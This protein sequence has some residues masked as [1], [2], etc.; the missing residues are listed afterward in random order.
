[1]RDAQRDKFFQVANGLNALSFLEAGDS[2]VWLGCHKD[3]MTFLA[4]LDRRTGTYTTYPREDST[5]RSYHENAVTCISAD[6]DGMLWYGTSGGGLMRFDP[7]R[8]TYRRYASRLG[9]PEALVNNFVATIAPDSGRL[10]VGTQEGLDLLDCRSGT[11]E[12]M[13]SPIPTNRLRMQEMVDDGEG[14]LWIVS[15]QSVA[16]FTK[17]RRAFRWLSIPNEYGSGAIPWGIAFDSPSRMITV[18]MGGGF[19]MF[20][21]DNPPA[22]SDPPPVVLTSFKVFEKPYPLDREIWSLPS[23]TIPHSASFFSF[24]FAALDFLNSA[25]N[26]YSYRLEGFDP[27][28][29]ETGTRRYVSYSNLDAGNYV[30]R[31]RGANSEGTWNDKGTAIAI[32]VLPAWYR[33]SWAY[34]VYALLAGGIL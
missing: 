27:D 3:G 7:L 29:V 11:F 17:A 23:I 19:F 1:M 25:S 20:S 34:G 8:K 15:Q 12:H 21:L 28:W 30:F 24:T 32:V 10:W 2:S 33:T 26:Q 6:R 18:G 9:S 16:C 22:A 13:N 14:H 31:V 5:S 4:L